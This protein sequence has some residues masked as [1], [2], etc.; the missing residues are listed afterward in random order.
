[1]HSNL[2]IQRKLAIL[3]QTLQDI[4]C[5]VVA[6]PDGINVVLVDDAT[7][8]RLYRAICLQP[9]LRRAE[10]WLPTHHGFHGMGR[11]A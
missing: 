7:D 3:G 11:R 1:M 5:R 2:N 6:A 4:G 10:T 9:G 8:E